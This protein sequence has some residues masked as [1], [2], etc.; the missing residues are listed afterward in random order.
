MVSHR[1]SLLGPKM[2][3]ALDRGSIGMNFCL[4]SA[5]EEILGFLKWIPKTSMKTIGIFQYKPWIFHY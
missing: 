3:T 5:R 4:E 1:G 2:P